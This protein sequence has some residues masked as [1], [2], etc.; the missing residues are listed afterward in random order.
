MSRMKLRNATLI[1]SIK[2]EWK[3]KRRNVAVVRSDCVT[4]SIHYI[5][6]FNFN[7]PFIVLNFVF[8]LYKL[9]SVAIGRLA[10][11]TLFLMLFLFF[12]HNEWA[13]FNLMRPNWKKKPKQTYKVNY[14][15]THA[16]WPQHRRNCKHVCGCGNLWTHY[17]IYGAL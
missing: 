9:V 15:V 8:I 17:S 12:L 11:L 3:C 7:L 10:S 16:K 14:T 5:H 6:L 13:P 2:I 1:K 4:L